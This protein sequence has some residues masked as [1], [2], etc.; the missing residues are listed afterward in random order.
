MI[1]GDTVPIFSIALDNGEKFIDGDTVRFTVRETADSPDYV[2]Q[3]DIISFTDGA[4]ELSFL[5]SDTDN[6]PTGRYV[7]GVRLL[8]LPALEGGN[9]IV[10][11]VIPN[12]PQDPPPLFILNEGVPRFE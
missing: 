12:R 5:R 9:P 2:F 10:A 7:Y 8:R 1:R 4:A 3:K 6:L 11:M